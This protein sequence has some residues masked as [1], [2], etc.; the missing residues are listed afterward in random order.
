MLQCFS[1][2]HFSLAAPEQPLTEVSARSVNDLLKELADL[3]N[4]EPQ[5]ACCLQG[6][7]LPAAWGGEASRQAE[8][9]SLRAGTG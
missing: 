2:Q 8:V 5:S 9:G 1:E 7:P 3:E 4:T 6:V